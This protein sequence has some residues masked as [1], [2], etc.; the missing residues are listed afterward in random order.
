[1]FAKTTGIRRGALTGVSTGLLYLT[2]YGT[3]GLAFWYGTSLVLN[4]EIDVGDMMTAF[5]GIIIAAFALGTVGSG[6]GRVF[7]IAGF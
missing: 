7:E 3:Y 5:F 1:M 4:N 6:L 2:M